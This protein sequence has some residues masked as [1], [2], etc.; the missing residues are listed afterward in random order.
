MG[1]YGVFF[2]FSLS[3]VSEQHS[4][5]PNEPLGYTPRTGTYRPAARHV[6]Q[7]RK[8]KTQQSRNESKKVSLRSED[9]SFLCTFNLPSP[10]D[11]VSDR[12]R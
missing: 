5:I 9:A 7:N 11:A 4:F 12:D 1:T 3:P 10:A 8:T 6:I 2:F